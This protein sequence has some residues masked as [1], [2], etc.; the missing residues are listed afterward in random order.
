MRRLGYLLIACGLFLTGSPAQSSFAAEP[1]TPPR[2]FAYVLQAD[3]VWKTRSQAVSALAGCDRDWIVVDA[4]Y[5]GEAEGRWTR[6]DLQT[7]RAGKPGRRVLAYLSIGEAE[8]Y[9]GY[10][11]KSWDA[12]RDGRPDAGA[13]DFLMPV[14]PDWAGNYRVRYW[15]AD[16]Q[17]LILAEVDR[18]S[19]Q[20]FDGA[21]LD[22]VDAFETFEF[23]GK[24][25]IND[26]PNKET[27]HTFRQDMIAWVTA[28]GER[29]RRDGP[30]RLLVPQNGSQ[31]VSDA[32]YREMVSAIGLE[33]VFTNGNRRQKGAEIKSRVRHIEPLVAASKPVL[34]IEY[35]KKQALR[36]EVIAEAHSH[37]FVWL[38]TDR[39]LKTLGESGN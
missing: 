32:A 19:A 30:T 26:R 10:W 23:D 6:E 2:S 34:L 13:P 21:Y 14:N 25:W 29:M 8:D 31:L 20:G 18:I 9:R 4:A 36:D 37:R 12:D 3:A 39:E 16:W 27:G 1:L 22:L 17:K 35:P 7:I 38:L 15:R 5:S 28:I 24:D 33:D 11:Q